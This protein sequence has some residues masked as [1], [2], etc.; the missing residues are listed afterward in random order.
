MLY[1]PGAHARHMSDE[2]APAALTYVPAAHPVHT[3]GKRAATTS[4]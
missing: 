2:L 1:N 3:E 4:L